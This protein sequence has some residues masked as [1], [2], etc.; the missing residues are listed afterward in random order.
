MTLFMF[1]TDLFNGLQWLILLFNNDLSNV[2]NQIVIYTCFTYPFIMYSM[3]GTVYILW[4]VSCVQYDMYCTV[5]YVQYIILWSVYSVQCTVCCTLHFIS[6]VIVQVR[7]LCTLY[8]V[9]Y[10]LYCTVCCVQCVCLPV[11][12]TPRWWCRWGWDFVPRSHAHQRSCWYK[13][14]E[15]SWKRAEKWCNEKLMLKK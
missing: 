4:T 15:R 2:Y 3:L 14:E 1:Y 8:T 12:S 6:T 7:I 9:Q 13:V 5:F 10:V 11:H